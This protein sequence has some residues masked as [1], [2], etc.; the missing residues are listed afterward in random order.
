MHLP[1]GVT[2]SQSTTTGPVIEIDTAACTARISL[3]GGHVLA[4]H[5]AGHA[6]VLWL[7]PGAVFREG[8]AIRGGIPVCWPWFAEHPQVPALP[9]HGFAR[10][11]DWTVEEAM[12]VG[13][14]IRLTLALPENHADAALWPHHS[15]PR[16]EVTA[17]NTL[18]LVLSNTNIDA[19]PIHLTQALHTYFAIG[20]IEAVHIDGLQGAAFHDKLTDTDGHIQAGSITFESEV[21]RIYRH[22]AGPIQIGDPKQQRTIAIRQTGGQSVV[23]WNPW[24][25]KTK[26]LGDMGPDDSYRGMVC[27]ETGSVG[28]DAMT[29]APGATHRLETIIS[30]EATAA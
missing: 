17:G 18:G 16:L 26:R 14:A 6:P 19:T 3:R 4:W 8:K 10:I 28:A 12:T 15:R 30:V 21:D 7:S 1:A 5:P 9:S 27:V 25:E 11:R 24:I 29:L 20:D 23:V 2:I 22:G 13:N